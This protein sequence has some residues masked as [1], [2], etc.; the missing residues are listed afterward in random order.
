M[1][2]LYFTQRTSKLRFTTEF[3]T[4]LY[5]SQLRSRNFLPTMITLALLQCV[6]PNYCLAQNNPWES[7][8]QGQNPWGATSEQQSNPPKK[9]RATP[10]TEEEIIVVDKSTHTAQK[11]K[12]GQETT[13]F[14]NG[15]SYQLKKG[16]RETLRFLKKQGKL[17]YNATGAGITS[18]MT[19]GLLNVVALPIN[20]VASQ[21]PTRQMKEMIAQFITDNP[22]ATQSEI[23]AYKK[24]IKTK[25]F[26]ISM[27]GSVL[28]IAAN[29]GIILILIL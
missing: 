26:G 22:H 13:Y 25:R 7:Q 3:L 11:V 17:D 4:G 28:G 9:E 6:T 12:Y 14:I 27:A 21:I 18:F 29:V 16:T 24:G 1:L 5:R 8:P 20:G 23:N 19:C 15:K 10:P 2:H